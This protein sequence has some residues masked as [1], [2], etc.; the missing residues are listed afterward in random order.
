MHRSITG[1][2][3]VAVVVA[4]AP[5]P[6]AQTGNSFQTHR[7]TTAELSAW[8]VAR[9]SNDLHSYEK[10][11]AAYPAGI[12]AGYAWS[13]IAEIEAAEVAQRNRGMRDAGMVP[14][15]EDRIS[16]PVQSTEGS[17]TSAIFSRPLAAF[18]EPGR[19]LA[20]GTS[21]PG[22]DEIRHYDAAFGALR[23]ADYERAAPMLASFAKSYP[24]DPLA[25][26]ARFW[27]G[28]IA[29]ARAEYT[30]AIDEFTET[31][32]MQPNGPKTEAAL[33]KLA[34]ALAA[35]GRST[36]ACGTYR[37]LVSEHP[38][39]PARLGIGSAAQ[40]RGPGC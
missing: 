18:H 24:S 4:F 14:A 1:L 22:G 37:R 11:I 7:S 12:F 10:Y 19:E 32:R 23:A 15:R 2:A 20:S 8:E 9:T 17:G 13:A 25:A 30:A 36:E 16:G 6:R 21:L 29:F 38:M 34:Q 31:I 33:Y 39:A 35:Q 3:A 5:C 26:N 28:E 27:L 40:R